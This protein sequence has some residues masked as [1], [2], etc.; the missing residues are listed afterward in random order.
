MRV[1]V[2]ESRARQGLGP[3]I[4]DAAAQEQVAAMAADALTRENGDGT[5]HDG[6]GSRRTRRPKPTTTASKQRKRADAE[7]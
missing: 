1:W 4:T 3:T 2:A 5:E 6:A 7:S